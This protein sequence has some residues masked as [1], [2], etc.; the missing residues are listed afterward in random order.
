M[1]P[2]LSKRG[3]PPIHIGGYCNLRFAP[4]PKIVNRQSQI[5]N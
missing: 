1:Q 3:N 2:R 5:I 4:P